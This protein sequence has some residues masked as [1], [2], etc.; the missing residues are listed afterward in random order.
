MISLIKSLKSYADLKNGSGLCLFSNY[1]LDQAISKKHYPSMK[2][3]SIECHVSESSVTLFSKKLG[4][5]GYRELIS[6]LKF[7]ITYFS[8]DE[9]DKEIKQGPKEKL[10]ETVFSSYNNKLQDHIVK[11]KTQL[12]K[13]SKLVDKFSKAKNIH[14]FSSYVLQKELNWLSI[15][16][17]I[18]EVRVIEQ[19][20]IFSDSFKLYELKENDLIILLIGDEKEVPFFQAILDTIPDQFKANL[21]IFSMSEMLSSNL[22]NLY[23]LKTDSFINY[24]WKY[25]Q[26]F[27]HSQSIFLKY[28]LDQ[29]AYLVKWKNKQDEFEEIQQLKNAE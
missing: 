7:E 21:F 26:L 4:F 29:L 5:T 24:G 20:N 27:E 10:E 22:A 25:H 6:K 9:I 2:Q 18:K 15:F 17:V 3:T 1:L 8:V 19:T 23:N 11:L 13:I 12:S 14:L 16:F 28:L